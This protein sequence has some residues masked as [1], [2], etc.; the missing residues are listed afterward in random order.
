MRLSRSG[1]LLI[2]TML[3]AAVLSGCLGGSTKNAGNG[4]VQS[5]TLN[6]SGMTSMTVGGT[7]VFSASARNASGG[8]VVGSITY[9]VSVPA[10]QSGAAPLSIAS[11]GNAC[12]GSW[13]PSVSIC[14]P[15]T[16]GVAVVTAVVDGVTSPPTTVY[17]HYHVD[18]LQIL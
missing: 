4:G 6:P 12:A 10:G 17:I 15:G 9:V 3:L 2:L 8:A 14:S 16:P 11:N 5:V 1:F 7:L 18:S 13:D